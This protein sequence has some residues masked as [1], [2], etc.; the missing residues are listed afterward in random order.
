MELFLRKGHPRALNPMELLRFIPVKLSLS[1]MAGILLGNWLEPHPAWAY[2]P[3]FLLLSLLGFMLFGR[4]GPT[5][6]YEVTAFAATLCL[7]MLAFG[8]SQPVYH[9]GHYTASD[10]HG[11]KLFHLKVREVL[12]ASSYNSRYTA[13]LIAMDSKMV[14]GK[15]LLAIPLESHG[16]LLN[17]DDELMVPASLEVTPKPLNPYQFNYGAYLKEL[18]I[19]HQ[20]RPGKVEICFLDNPTPTL[21][22]YAAGLRNTI[23]KRLAALGFAGEELAIVN[24]LLLGQRTDISSGTY[25]AYKNAGAVHLLAV[26]GLHIGILLWILHMVF[27]PVE[28]LPKGKTIKLLVLLVA[29]W[30]YAVLAGLSA[31]II[32]AVSMFSFVAYALYLNRPANTFN[33]L[34]LSIFFVLLAFD[35]RLLYS[36]GFQMSYAAVF[37]IV[38][39]YPKLQAI[40]RPGQWLPRKIWQLLSVSLAAQLGVLPISLF[41]FHQFPALFFVSNLLVVPFLGLLLGTGFLIALLAL[42]QLLPPALA[43]VYEEIIGAL[44]M[45]IRWV[46]SQQAFVFRDIPFDGV[47]IILSYLIICGLGLIL[48]K[49][50]YKRVV[51]LLAGIICMQLWMGFRLIR[52]KGKE[53]VWVLQQTGD[54]RV[55]HQSGNELRVASGTGLQDTVMLSGF[56]VA[57]GIAKIIEA[58]LASAYRWENS[59]LYIINEQSLLPR[60]PCGDTY[61]LFRNSPK[62]HFDR[63]LENTTP[64]AVIADGSNYLSYVARWEASCRARNIPFHNTATDGAFRL[65][66][67]PAL[68]HSVHQL[69]K[70]GVQEDGKQSYTDTEG[71]KNT[72]EGA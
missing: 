68:T 4:V 59:C 33:I 6:C 67:Q 34:A 9:S 17:V 58:P 38:W 51:V 71:S 47:M 16:A 27:R 8:L 37:A 28:L 70:K 42:F 66:I 14:T 5:P 23:I 30:S 49:I 50:N 21:R 40:W 56:R 11:V 3:A 45:V 10:I 55:F 46:A 52:L 41:Y 69:F 36:P 65:Q 13:E 57:E 12:K 43:L 35:A 2:I 64:K 18:G 31:S 54:T 22:G 44:N 53:V 39:I 7:G 29:L 72:K 62:I 19:L 24:A 63:L 15:L 60:V 26:S 32:R 48:S 25:D 61:L 1:L 20:I